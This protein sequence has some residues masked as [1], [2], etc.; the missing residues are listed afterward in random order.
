M[1]MNRYLLIAAF[2]MVSI[3]VNAEERIQAFV[4]GSYSQ[5][6]EERQQKTFVLVFWSLTCPSCYKELK[7][8]GEFK[9]RYSDID[10]VLVS[11][12][13]TAT[14]D[15]LYNVLSKYK[16]GDV[17]S[18]VFSIDSD[19]RLRFEIDHS[20]YGELPRSYL[21]KSSQQKQVVSGLLSIKKLKMWINDN[22]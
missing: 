21:F 20:W 17:E 13:S 4:A 10:I 9:L 5:I 11:T 12:D 7:M 3:S 15:E 16:L 2:V 6:L 14:Q 18:W 8:L 22:E 1:L 19:E